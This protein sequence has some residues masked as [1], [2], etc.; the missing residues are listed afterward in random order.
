LSDSIQVSQK[1][2][3]WNAGG[4]ERNMGEVYIPVPI[5]IHKKYPNFFPSRDEVSSL[6]IPTGE[7][8]RAKLCQENA[9]ALMTN[10]NKAISD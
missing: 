9:K 7:I 5:E 1:L 10:P 8:F 4:R 6:Q 2:N 3:Q